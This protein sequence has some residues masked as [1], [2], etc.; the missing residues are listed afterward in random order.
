MVIV[1]SISTRLLCWDTLSLTLVLRSLLL[2]FAF[3]LLQVLLGATVVC[4]MVIFVR[5]MTEERIHSWHLTELVKLRMECQSWM[6]V[7]MGYWDPYLLGHLQFA[8]LAYLVESLDWDVRES[9]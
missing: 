3:L 2:F 9:S 5:K 4:I 7:G 6:M 8:S 1:V